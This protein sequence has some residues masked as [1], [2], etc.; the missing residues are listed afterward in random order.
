MKLQFTK[1]QGAGGW[2]VR[3][4]PPLPDWPSDDALVDTLRMN[5][6]IAAE[7]QRDPAQYVGAQAFQDA[8]RGRR[9]ALLTRA[10]AR[11]TDTGE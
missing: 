6:W 5:R 4:L 8:T 7:V 10:K 3:F 2:R 9:P 1:M 11:S